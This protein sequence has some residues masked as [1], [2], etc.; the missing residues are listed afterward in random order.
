MCFVQI[1]T[2]EA[3]EATVIAGEWDVVKIVASNCRDAHG[4]T[5]LHQ[6]AYHNRLNV[7]NL[8]KTAPGIDVN[9]VDSLGNTPLFTALYRE[10][11]EVAKCLLVIDGI[12]VNIRNHF[13]AASLVL[14]VENGIIDVLDLLLTVPGVNVNLADERGCNLLLSALFDERWEVARGLLAKEGINVN[15]VDKCKSTPLHYAIAIEEPQLDIVKR[16]WIPKVLM[17]MCWITMVKLHFTL[18]HKAADL[19][20]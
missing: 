5:P 11:V 2:D 9:T 13:G 15:A 1:D 14:A 19:T 8:L 17:S 18:Q 7:F 10:H 4:L 16:L 12:N 6:A 3:F 20:C